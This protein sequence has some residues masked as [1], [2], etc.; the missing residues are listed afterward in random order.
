MALP[1]WNPDRVTGGHDPD[2]FVGGDAQHALG[3]PQELAARMRVRF[4]AGLRIEIT[5]IRQHR[6]LGVENESPVAHMKSWRLINI[7]CHSITLTR[8]RSLR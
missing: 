1:A 7:S 5:P 4:D 6:L 8:Q 2:L 3:R